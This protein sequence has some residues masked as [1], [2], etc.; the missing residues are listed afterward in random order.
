MDRLSRSARSQLMAK[1]RSRN[2][3]PELKVRGVAHRLG[4][5][6]RIHDKRLPGTPDLIFPRL[7]LAMFV[8]GCFWHRHSG[9]SRASSPATNATTWSDKF[10]RNIAR[11]AKAVSD[12]TALGWDCV[13]IWECETRDT[14]S[15]EARLR[16]ELKP[17]D[18]ARRGSTKK[19]H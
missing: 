16:N 15:L 2:S 1:V 10:E 8:H 9:C 14:A 3:K 12:L 17:R 4:Y 18:A 11:D 7:R 5:R 13:I 19:T 6:F